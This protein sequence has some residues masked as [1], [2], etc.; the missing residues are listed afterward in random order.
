MKGFLHG[1]GLT[2]VGQGTGKI[3]FSPTPT[4]VDRPKQK[5]SIM[6]R[7]DYPLKSGFPQ[8]LTWL[9]VQ[10]CYLQ[11]I[12]NRILKLKYLQVLDLAHNSIK[13]LPI[14][15]AKIKL[16][17][18]VMH[19][20]ELVHFPKELST[21]ALGQTLQVLDLSFNQVSIYK[22]TESLFLCNFFKLM[23]IAVFFFSIYKSNQRAHARISH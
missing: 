14:A 16:K 3:H 11:R 1:V 2:I 15:L 8:S 9:Q 17:E 6:E 5:L 20:N 4:K 12:D 22:Y 7:Q 19:H 13:E 21:G 18:L 10:T 23:H